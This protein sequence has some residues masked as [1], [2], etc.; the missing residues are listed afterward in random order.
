[1]SEAEAVEFFRVMSWMMAGA[2]VTMAVFVV[3]SML[4]TK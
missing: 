4:R 2:M 1:M 3:L